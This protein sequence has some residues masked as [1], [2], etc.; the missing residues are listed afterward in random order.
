MGS[1]DSGTLFDFD[2]D[3]KIKIST[4]VQWFCRVEM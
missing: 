2:E 3:E 1:A 4:K